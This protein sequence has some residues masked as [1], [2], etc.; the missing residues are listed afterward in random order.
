MKNRETEPHETKP[1]AAEPIMKDAY[2]GDICN[3]V[4]T[5][6]EATALMSDEDEVLE[7]GGF[8]IK[9]W[10]STTQASETEDKSEIAIGGQF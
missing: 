7:G 10:I 9:Q 3:S 4:N 6:Q 5:L 1:K 2:A 8:Y